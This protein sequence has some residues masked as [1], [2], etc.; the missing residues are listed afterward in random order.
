MN[1]TAERFN[2]LPDNMTVQQQ[3]EVQVEIT[4]LSFIYFPLTQKVDEAKVIF[5]RAM[6]IFLA[7]LSEGNKKIVE[8]ALSDLAGE[9]GALGVYKCA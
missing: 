7:M 3:Y 5:K 1:S 2:A 4:N 9:F 6:E 8:A